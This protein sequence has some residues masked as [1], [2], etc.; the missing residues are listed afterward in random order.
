MAAADGIGEFLYFDPPCTFLFTD[1]F[2]LQRE[3]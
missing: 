2:F 1:F 3:D